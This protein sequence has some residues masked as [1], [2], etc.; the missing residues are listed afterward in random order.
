MPLITSLQNPRIK[1]LVMLRD[2]R[3]RDQSGVFLVEGYEEFL[4]ALES[5]AA[6]D[7]VFYCPLMFHEAQQASLLD[8]ARGVGAE[9]VEVD[10]R[11]FDKIAY[12]DNPD[13]WLATFP[14][15]ARGL[16]RLSLKG[17]PLVIVGEAVEKPGN[18]GAIL[19]TADAAGVDAVISC[20]PLTDGALFSVQVAEASSAETI[21]WL[22]ERQ[23]RIVAA[24]PDATLRYDLA[25]LSGPL[26]IA[27]GTEKHGL[28]KR[29]L[30]QADEAVAIPM[31][32]KVNSLNVATATALLVYEAVRQRANK[33]RT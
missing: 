10:E 20:D 13:G 21:A 12:R 23:L 27:V 5:G 30:D 31:V 33:D 25:D 6:P 11:V 32:G 19:R 2:R 18:L 1:A 14:L 16:D 24:V 7:T 29:W 9:L 28:S 4:L 26:A 17:N 3:K 22:R 15:P 8:R